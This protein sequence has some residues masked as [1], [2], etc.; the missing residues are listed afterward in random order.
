MRG[1]DGMVARPRD[2]T[3]EP[4]G[5][6]H[7]TFLLDDGSGKAPPGKKML[8]A[9]AGGCVRLS[10]IGADGHL[11]IAEG[12]ETAL[13]ARAIFGVPT[14]AV[15]SAD[16]LRGWQWPAGLTHVT[17]FAD[18]GHAGAQAA[19]ALADR[20][21]TAGIANEIL[22]PLHGDDFN[23]DLGRSATAADYSAPIDEPTPAILR[24]VAEFDARRR[25]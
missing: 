18:A 22:S 5:G 9:I 1:F 23:D 24:T 14:W 12:I 21:N 11:G 2:V 20:L 7:R 15:L 16:G 8:G 6:I 17:I 4:V 25:R 3:G 13:S 19:A 10:P